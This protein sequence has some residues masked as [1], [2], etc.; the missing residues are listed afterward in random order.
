M[1]A[2][3]NYMVL[4]YNAVD[5][6]A[7]W[8]DASKFPNTTMRFIDNGKQTFPEHLQE[9]LT[10]QNR[11][12]IGCSGGWNLALDI[13]FNHLGLEKVIIGQ[14]DA[15]VS[16]EVFE[17][18]LA[19]CNPDTI[20]GTYNNG[21]NF[22]TYAMHRDTFNRIGRFDENFVFVGCE[23]NDYI[24]RAKLAG[25]EIKSLGISNA[26]NASIAN[27]NNVVPVRSSQHNA[28][29]I[30]RKWNNYTYDIPW[31]GEAVSRYTDYFK[32]LYGEPTIWPSE[33]EFNLFKEKQ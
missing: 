16:E 21:F 27:N 33:M 9:N 14:E 22:S 6:F 13:A 4:G 7:Q 2:K 24:H 11:A 25:V 28:D 15:R 12:N 8:W 26:F 18:L 20:C 23:D 31:N 29:Y 30:A 3:Y 32:E 10:H 1:M 19:E 5:Y 17:A